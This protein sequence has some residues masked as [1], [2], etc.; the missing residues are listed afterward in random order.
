MVNINICFL[1]VT[2]IYLYIIRNIG[3]FMK[4]ILIA[5]LLISIVI[6]VGCYYTGQ[7]DYSSKNTRFPVP[8]PSKSPVEIT[9]T[10]IPMPP[11]LPE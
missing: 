9:E 7:V 6:M 2:F 3:D 5:F 11:P 10:S 4:K 1:T 8:E